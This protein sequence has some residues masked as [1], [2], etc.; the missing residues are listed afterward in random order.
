MS[1]VRIKSRAASPFAARG[2]K[3]RVAKPAPGRADP[4]R[5]A[6]S[7]SARPPGMRLLVALRERIRLD[8]VLGFVDQ[9]ELTIELGAT[10][11]SVRPQVMVFVDT[12]IPFG[13]I[14]EFN[15][16]RSRRDLVDVE[17]AGLLGG[18]FPQPR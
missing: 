7:Q 16:G 12:H 9:L 15:T 6:Q 5:R 3:A 11:A 4:A 1:S 2:L 13:R 14:L 8:E 17:A 18:Q 10:D